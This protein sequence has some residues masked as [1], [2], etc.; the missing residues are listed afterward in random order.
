MPST[1]KTGGATAPQTTKTSQ[2]RFGKEAE[3]KRTCVAV[4][5]VVPELHLAEEYLRGR[6]AF[7]DVTAVVSRDD[8]VPAGTENVELADCQ[9]PSASPTRSNW[10]LLV[11]FL[12]E[13][14]IFPQPQPYGNGVGKQQPS[15]RPEC[16]E[17]LA[18]Q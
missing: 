11:R 3:G 2:G 5:L 9:H 1:L 14:K 7:H 13:S 10:K 8:G 6:R 16:C 17:T 4:V 18:L 12:W 15:I